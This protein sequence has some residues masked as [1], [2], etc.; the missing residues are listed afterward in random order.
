MQTGVTGDEI[1]L[2]GASSLSPILEQLFGSGLFKAS[3]CT[4]RCGGSRA[5]YSFAPES[6]DVASP[7]TIALSSTGAQVR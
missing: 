7:G 3:Q 5:V 4:G 6:H 2:K 1:V